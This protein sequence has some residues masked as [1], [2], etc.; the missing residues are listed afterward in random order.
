MIDG[1]AGG[2]ENCI[3]AAERD[4]RHAAFV[5]RLHKNG[6]G[7]LNDIALPGNEDAHRRRSR[8]DGSGFLLAAREWGR[9]NAHY[10]DDDSFS[11]FK[12][13]HDPTI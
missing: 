3:V 9:K 2:P 11:D 5:L 6:N 4:T 8:V 7:R 1:R 12:I 10:G 13:T